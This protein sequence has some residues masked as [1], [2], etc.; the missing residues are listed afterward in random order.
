MISDLIEAQARM[1]GG[2]EKCRRTFQR[3]IDLETLA[4]MLQCNENAK[5]LKWQYTILVI[6]NAERKFIRCQNV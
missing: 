4:D 5:Q 6:V 2:A 3:A 1:W